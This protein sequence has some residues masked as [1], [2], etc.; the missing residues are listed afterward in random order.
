MK[1]LKPAKLAVVVSLPSTEGVDGVPNG[2][3]AQR[4]RRKPHHLDDY[5]L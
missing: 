3:R 4:V 2:E 1:A 5:E